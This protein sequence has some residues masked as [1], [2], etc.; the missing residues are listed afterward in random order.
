M[1]IFRGFRTPAKGRHSV[2]A[3]SGIKRRRVTEDELVDEVVASLNG[4][5]VLCAGECRCRIRPGGVCQFG[6]RDL[7]KEAGI[8]L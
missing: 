7:A 2:K 1:L 3:R 8:L 6:F 5:R 4:R